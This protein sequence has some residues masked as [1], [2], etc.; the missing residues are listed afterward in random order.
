MEDEDEDP[1]RR[2]K[3]N[4]FR[5]MFSKGQYCVCKEK[6]SKAG[7]EAQDEE[8]ALEDDSENF[9]AD[10]M[11]TIAANAEDGM[12]DPRRKR[13]WNK[14]KFAMFLKKL[15]A[16]HFKAKSYGCYCTQHKGVVK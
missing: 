5:P 7:D 8:L 9:V 16:P 12:S 1:A 4:R 3:K 2:R 6:V 10:E 11:E 13:K 14:K 15:V